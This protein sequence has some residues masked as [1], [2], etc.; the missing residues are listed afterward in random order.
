MGANNFLPGLHPHVAVAVFV[1]PMQL[2]LGLQELI[3]SGFKEENI[4]I[5]ARNDK[6]LEK[7]L[8]KVHGGERVWPESPCSLSQETEATGFQEAREMALGAGLAILAGM[9]SFALPGLG[10]Y[11]WAAGPLALLA[12]GLSLGIG[13]AGLGAVVGAILDER[14]TEAQRKRFEQMIIAGHWLLVA[15]GNYEQVTRTS[16][17]LRASPAIEVEVF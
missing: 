7:V 10:A 13:G 14:S 6:Q 4:S 9:T 11:L 17:V 12:H 5:L 1:N 3:A 8:S 16:G 2:S 15:H